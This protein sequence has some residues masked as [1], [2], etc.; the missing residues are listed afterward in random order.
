MKNFKIWRIF[1]FLYFNWSVLCWERHFTFTSEIKYQISDFS[2][3]SISELDSDR[4]LQLNLWSFS[5]KCSEKT[6]KKK[7]NGQLLQDQ[8]I[9]WW[10]REI[11]ALKKAWVRITGNGLTEK[12][13]HGNVTM[14]LPGF[15]LQKQSW[16]LLKHLCLMRRNDEVMQCHKSHLTYVLLTTLSYNHNKL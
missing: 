3:T 16:T 13:E 15:A 4:V 10:A 8:H 1:I 5:W 7:K 2:L 6:I 12:M 11:K 14:N 9:K